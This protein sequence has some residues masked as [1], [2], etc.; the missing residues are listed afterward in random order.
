MSSQWAQ[1]RQTAIILGI[2]VLIGLFVFAMYTLV[3]YQKPTCFDGELNGIEEGTDCGGACELVCP[4]SATEVNILWA[5]A[6]K[7][8]DGVYNFTGLLENPNFDVKVDARYKFEAYTSENLLIRDVFGDITL[9]PTQRKPIFEATINTGFQEI[10][11]VFLKIVGEP[12]WTKADQLEQTV[13][14]ASR[15][16]EDVDT[17]PKLEVSL[18]NKAVVPKR[19]LSIVAI[20]YNGEG[21]VI[22]SSATYLDY[23]ERDSTESV[24]YTWPEPFAEEVTKIEVF[25]NEVSLF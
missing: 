13:F 17:R 20:L 7:I 16:L 3:F 21:N 11:R 19:N 25:I 6:F 5:R 24:F 1:N 14:I 9:Y 18:T 4:F 23:I 15:K 8:S 12:E 10:S 22:Q 2:L